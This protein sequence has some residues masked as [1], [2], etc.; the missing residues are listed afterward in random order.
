[1]DTEECREM[2]SE[3]AAAAFLNQFKIGQG[4][5]TKT[6]MTKPF[7]SVSYHEYSITEQFKHPLH[8]YNDD[9]DTEKEA[10]DF[11]MRK[12]YYNF[13]FIQGYSRKYRQQLI[14]KIDYLE[15]INMYSDFCNNFYDLILVFHFDAIMEKLTGMF[16]GIDETSQVIEQPFNK[17]R[18]TIICNDV[19]KQGSYKVTKTFTKQTEIRDMIKSKLRSKYGCKVL[20]KDISGL[21]MLAKI[22]RIEDNDN[23][24]KHS[25]IGYINSFIYDK[26]LYLNEHGNFDNSTFYNKEYCTI[27]LLLQDVQFTHIPEDYDI[28]SSY[29]N[30]LNDTFL[31]NFHHIRELS[32]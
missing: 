22:K 13:K 17:F 24:Y 15:S 8:K 11:M 18:P 3:E 10:H 16:S 28:G 31:C 27:N 4:M 21:T 23:V 2:N 26:S 6:G 9:F 32:I 12:I 5:T 7:F 25:D 20:L 14:Q 30:G 1:M 19:L 29:Y